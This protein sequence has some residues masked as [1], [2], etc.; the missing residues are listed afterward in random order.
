M[1]C[2]PAPRNMEL[3]YSNIKLKTRAETRKQSHYTLD[4][5]ETQNGFMVHSI[6]CSNCKSQNSIIDIVTGL[7]TYQ[8][9][10]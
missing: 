2:I 9:A 8:T 5:N 1:W 10:D 6:I 4:V 3:W 7:H